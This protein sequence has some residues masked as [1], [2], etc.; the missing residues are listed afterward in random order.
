MKLS[1]SVPSP[2]RPQVG[3]E[4][5]LAK[6]RR[7]GEHHGEPVDPHPQSAGRRHAVLHGVQKILVHGMSFGVSLCRRPSLIL[8]ALA[9]VLGVVQLAERVHDLEPRQEE[10]EALD[11]AR[12]P[13]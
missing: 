4:D 8:E 5:H 13:R 1:A 2:F 10:L 6:V 11:Q 12:I 9:L 3:E 7:V